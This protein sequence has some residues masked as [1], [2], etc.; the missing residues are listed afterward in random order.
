MTTVGRVLTAKAEDTPPNRPTKGGETGVS[1]GLFHH[2]IS[3]RRFLK[4]GEKNRR[5]FPKPAP[6][7]VVKPAKA[8]LRPEKTRRRN[9][10]FTAFSTFFRSL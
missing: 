5:H 3:I 4:I 8:V 1:F 2:R 6:K 7:K 10:G 9:T